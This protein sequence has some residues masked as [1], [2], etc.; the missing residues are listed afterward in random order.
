M[1]GRELQRHD[2]VRVEPAAY[3][4]Y[5][6][7]HPALGAGPLACGWA[8]AG[9]PLIVRRFAPGESSSRV[10]LGLPLPCSAEGRRRIALAL[11]PDSVTACPAPTLA[12]MRPIAPDAWC[13][14]LDALVA[15]GARH[16]LVPRPFGSLL[17]QA[18]T[19]LDY[20]HP[21]SDLDVL[22]PIPDPWAPRRLRDLLDGIAGLTEA[23]PMR[24]DGEVLLPGGGGV[25]WRE[26]RETPEDGAVLVKH[27]DWLE[28]RPAGAL[29]LETTGGGA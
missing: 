26:L 1:I 28:M 20:L 4:A 17:W 18:V 29:L 8:E 23:A 19:G 24:L 21:G 12:A 22:W 5:L 27:R 13:R 3:A 10:P 6:R 11:P 7:D 14:T 25:Q 9:R 2:L 15:L 16:G